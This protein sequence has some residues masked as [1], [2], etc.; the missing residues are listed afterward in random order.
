[1]TFR[2]DS[3]MKALKQRERLNAQ[4]ASHNLE[5]WIIQ[6]VNPL[7][8]AH[9]LDLGCGRGKQVF[10]LAPLV[11]PHGSIL[12]VDISDEAVKEINE[13]ARKAGFGNVRATKAALDDC[14]GLLSGC[15]FDYVV[16]AYA[17]YYAKDMKRLLSE[18]RSLLNPG[19]QMFICGPGRGTN[20]EIIQLIN[21]T[22]KESTRKVPPIEDFIDDVEVRETGKPYSNYRIIRL[23]NEI[24]FP[25]SESVLCWWEN[26]NSFIPESRAAVS[27][28]LQFHFSRKQEF[29]LTKNVL[30]VQYF[31]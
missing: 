7:R 27:Q 14:I 18:L 13:R 8:G 10:A 19:G 11:S 29:V 21:E 4:C 30:G 31:A 28:A 23:A 9:V 24:R 3:D 17:I 6:H 1:M 15:G 25:S 16:S 12:G 2:F 26:H 5:E 20:Q 22:L